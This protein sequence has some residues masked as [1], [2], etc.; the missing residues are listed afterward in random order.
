MSVPDD[1][2]VFILSHGRAG[3]VRTLDALERCGYTGK[4]WIVIDDEDSQGELY[5]SE[6]GGHVLVF[7]K[8]EVAE[9]FDEFETG[10]SRKTVV[11]AR[12]ACFALAEEVGIKRFMELDDDYTQFMFRFVDGRKLAFAECSDLDEVINAYL[13]WLDCSG[14]LSVAFAQGGDFVGGANSKRIR[15]RVWRKAMNSFM[16]DT[17]RAFKFVG[18]VNEDVNT[19]CTLGSRGGLFLTSLDFMLCQETTQKSAGGM[20]GEYLD[21]GTYVKSFY[22]VMCCPS[23]VKV[24]VLNTTHPRI[25][26]NVDWAHGVPKILSDRYRRA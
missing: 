9:T 19:Y 16:C 3:R 12:N 5:R 26:H 13:E 15:D 22:S 21:S 11:Y 25:H 2:G 8:A 1:F 18:R 17:S 23:F 7:S 4:W 6:Y 14:A 20:S 10:G 24:S